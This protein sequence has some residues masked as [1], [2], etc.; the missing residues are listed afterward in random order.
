MVR[1]AGFD[2]LR[3]LAAAIVVFSH[4]FLIAEG[5]ESGEQGQMFTGEILGVYA[6]MIIF[7]LSGF[8]VTDSASA[9]ADSSS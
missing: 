9:S 4:S 7:V 2:S 8:P 1:Y 3:I 6:V 5:V